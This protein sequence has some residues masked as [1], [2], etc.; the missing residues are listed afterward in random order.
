MAGTL[1]WRGV[2]PLGSGC[3]P[4]A[5]GT[6][7]GRLGR[8]RRRRA[9]AA[10]R[11]PDRAGRVAQCIDRPRCD[12]RA[13]RPR[14][15]AAC[16]I[17]TG[18]SG[19]WPRLGKAQV[20]ILGRGNIQGVAGHAR[21]DVRGSEYYRRLCKTG[22]W[23]CPRRLVLLPCSTSLWPPGWSRIRYP[24]SCSPRQEGELALQPVRTI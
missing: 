8:R 6:G 22:S 7:P 2:D 16:S 12:N 21:P 4:S 14:R 3:R 11:R 20:R 17:S 23:L 10:G 9:F 24:R 19:G 18:Y 1:I 5:R 13:V 15:C